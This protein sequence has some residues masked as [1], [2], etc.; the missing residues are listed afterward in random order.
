[1]AAGI[2]A[3]APVFNC[4]LNAFREVLLTHQ[5][6]E[7]DSEEGDVEGD[8]YHDGDGDDDYDE[9]LNCNDEENVSSNGRNNKVDFVVVALQKFT[10]DSL[11]PVLAEEVQP[12]VSCWRLLSEI[13]QGRNGSN[14]CSLISLQIGYAFFKTTLRF[15]HNNLPYQS[16]S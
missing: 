11:A 15:R 12:G 1:M 10:V 3:F 13:S 8:G 4:E 14:A 5:S 16:T 6:D 9:E 7:V 2:V